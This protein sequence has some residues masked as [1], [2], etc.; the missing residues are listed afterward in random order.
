MIVGKKVGAL[1]NVVEALKSSSIYY[2]F[3]GILI[4]YIDQVNGKSYSR[5]EFIQRKPSQKIT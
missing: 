1:P 2:S 5:I 3:S 4:D